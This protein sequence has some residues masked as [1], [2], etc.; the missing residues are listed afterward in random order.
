MQVEKPPE[1]ANGAASR[2]GERANPTGAL[3]DVDFP[4]QQAVCIK[5]KLG[6][7][8]YGGFAR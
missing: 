3:G 6:H 2:S 8:K 1:E 7:E 4:I 5:D